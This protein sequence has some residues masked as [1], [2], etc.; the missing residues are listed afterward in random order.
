M[1]S[2]LFYGGVI[3]GGSIAYVALGGKPAV[4][5]TTVKH[6]KN[7]EDETYKYFNELTLEE[8]KRYFSENLDLRYYK[9]DVTVGLTDDKYFNAKH[10]QEISKR[11]G[12][13]FT[14]IY[15]TY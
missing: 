9:D 14:N 11:V 5:E 10:A 2:M 6:S 12:K 4:K 7:Y 15:K 13:P 8:Q 3:I 1:L